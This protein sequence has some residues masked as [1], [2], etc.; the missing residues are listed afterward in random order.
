MQATT[1]RYL[2]AVAFAAA[3]WLAATPALATDASAPDATHYSTKTPYRYVPTEFTPAPPG[4][5]PVLVQYVGRH[6]SRHLSSAKYDKTLFELL[7]IAEARGQLTDAGYT[8]KQEVAQLIAVQEDVYGE[9]SMLGGEE[10]HAIG[11]RLA[12]R[13]PEAFEDGQ[14]IIAHATYKDRTPQSRDHFLSGLQSAL[15]EA[16]PPIDA[17]QYAKGRDPYLRP[18]DL[19][20]RYGDYKSDGEWQA[21]INAFLDAQSET[22]T[23]ARDIVT[24]FIDDELYAELE[25]GELALEDA[26]GRVALATPTDAAN[27]LYQLY[28]IS[29]NIVR[30]G[31]FDFGRYFSEEQ[32]AWYEDL[33]LMETF[34]AKG[35]SLTSSDLPR[36]IAA[37]MVKELITS[38]DEALKKDSVS[39]IFNFTHA[40]LIMPLAAYLQIEGADESQD[41]PAQVSASWA[42]K[43][44]TAMAANIQ[45]ILFEN[46]NGGDPLV[47][48]L[49]NEREIAFPLPTEQY[50]YYDWESVKAYY[51]A[52]VNDSGIA[53]SNTL[54]EDIEALEN[55]F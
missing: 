53:L 28:I 15:G 41:D 14:P 49:H 32:L 23:F 26:K 30:E 37:P 17:R 8:L 9:L 24:Q 31:E 6:G 1:N 47:K 13:F 39:G 43:D 3:G 45:W 48:M 55:D 52:K 4:Y 16:T 10:L 44:I 40:E 34:Y 29:P 12:E 46:D 36:E 21:V 42:G 50:P 25:R 33:D 51:I 11:E 38:T 22:A 7:S 27:N 18:Y 2:G 35:P 54:D 19:A 20:A 5:R